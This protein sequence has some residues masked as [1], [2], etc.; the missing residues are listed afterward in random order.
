MGKIEI[1]SKYYDASSMFHG[2][3]ANIMGTRFDMLI[4]EGKKQLCEAVWYAVASDLQYLDHMLNRFDAKSE[5][6]R[7]NEKAAS[8]TVSLSAEMWTILL[9]CQQYCQKTFGLFDVTLKNF[10]SL[11][12][13]ESNH[14]VSFSIP[15][16]SLDLGGYAKGYAMNK[17]K[18]I[19][20][21][22]G[23]KDA[24]VDFGSS[25]ILGFGHHPYGDSWKVAIQ[26]PFDKQQILDEVLLRDKALSVSGNTPT[27]SEHIVRPDSGKYDRTQKLVAIIAD[28]PLDAE[29]LTTTWMIASVNEKKRLSK[30][31]EI[32]KILEYNLQEKC[33]VKN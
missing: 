24:F 26:N 14:S 21:D 31:F 4:I 15:D 1:V 29:V 27:Y 12:F 23:I 13:N 7:I 8:E 22:A 30:N 33:D 5:I 20:S 19:L 25:S 3:L 18:A 2:K 16:I 32:E 10:S 11:V 9:N 6:F 28:N 17:I